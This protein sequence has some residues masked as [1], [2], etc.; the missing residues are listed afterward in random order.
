[1]GVLCVRKLFV[2]VQFIMV[3]YLF[4]FVYVCLFYSFS[5]IPGY[6][7]ITFCKNFYSL[8]LYPLSGSRYSLFLVRGLFLVDEV[9]FLH[10]EYSMVGVWKERG[11]S[12]DGIGY[13]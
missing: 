8:T 4:V 12:V 1:M 9:R 13:H 10:F 11:K 7:F 3:L 6:F 2:F 5:K